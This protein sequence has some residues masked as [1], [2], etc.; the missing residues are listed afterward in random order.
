M[1]KGLVRMFLLVFFLSFA[2]VLYLES[3]LH[4]VLVSTPNA[5]APCMPAP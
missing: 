5:N 2:N 4:A 3:D 1:T